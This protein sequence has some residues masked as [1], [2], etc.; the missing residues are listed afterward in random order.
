MIKFDLKKYNSSD[1]TPIEPRVEQRLTKIKNEEQLRELPARL[2]DDLK[3]EI[4]DSSQLKCLQVACFLHHVARGEQDEAEDLLKANP[5][6]KFLLHSGEFTDYSGRTFNCTAFEYAWWAK[7]IHMCLMLIGYMDD[8]IKKGISSRC[9]AI[10]MHGLS[11]KQGGKDKNSKHFDFEPIKTALLNYI[12]GF[13]NQPDDKRQI[14]WM[15]VG[16]AQRD[17]PAH[18]AQEYCRKEG[19]F[20]PLQFNQ[21][22]LPRNLKFYNCNTKSYQYWFPLLL[23]ENMGLGVNCVI[24]MDWSSIWGRR[25]LGCS[26]YA[27]SSSCPDARPMQYADLKFLMLLDEVRSADFNKLREKLAIASPKKSPD[28]ESIPQAIADV[29][30][31]GYLSENLAKKR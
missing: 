17:L 24:Y 20:S 9:D 16:V 12:T 1:H 25:P 8:E 23:D 10:E 21:E 2:S 27:G 4:L 3:D 7:D 18:V 14:A 30:D 11:H 29:M 28:F 22:S 26:S 19:P 15:E 6:P 31:E 13:K 5:D